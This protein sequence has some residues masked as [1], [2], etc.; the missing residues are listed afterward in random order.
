MIVTDDL[1]ISVFIGA[2]ELN[3]V[4]VGQFQ[5]EVNDAIT[6]ISQRTLIE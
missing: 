4:C 3:G 6:L 2:G 1:W 5:H